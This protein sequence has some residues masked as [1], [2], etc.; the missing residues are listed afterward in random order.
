MV[1]TDEQKDQNERNHRKGKP[2]KHALT[3]ADLDGEDAVEI[4]DTDTSGTGYSALLDALATLF[5][6]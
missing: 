6:S 1:G 5:K 2:E 4:L 3:P